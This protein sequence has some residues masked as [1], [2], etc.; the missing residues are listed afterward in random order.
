[1]FD[2]SILYIYIYLFYFFCFILCFFLFYLVR[3][4]DSNPALTH[5]HPT[6]GVLSCSYCLNPIPAYHTTATTRTFT[7]VAACRS[8]V[9][10]SITCSP[11][12]CG[13][14]L[15]HIFTQACDIH[16]I[17]CFTTL[18]RT[19]AIKR[20]T[21]FLLLAWVRTNAPQRCNAQ[22]PLVCQALG[23]GV[24]VIFSFFSH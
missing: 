14:L 17:T 16:H 15:S 19:M 6:N 11:H 12:R 1:M 10:R 21:D 2:R 24:S 8:F 3:A 5:K 18:K 9:V 13:L 4:R 7:T 23:P 22:F 20:S